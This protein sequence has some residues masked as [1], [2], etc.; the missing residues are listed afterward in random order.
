MLRILILIIGAGPLLF[1]IILI[2]VNPDN[3]IITD[4]EK[5]SGYFRGGKVTGGQNLAFYYIFFFTL[6]RISWSKIR[7]VD[8]KISF[9]MDKYLTVNKKYRKYEKIVWLQY[10]QKINNVFPTKNILDNLYFGG[11][12]YYKNNLDGISVLVKCNYSKGKYWYSL[13]NLDGL[14]EMIIF[15]NIKDVKKLAKPV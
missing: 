9:L 7:E 10:K 2:I 5:F 1:L 8:Y 11:L 13:H 15:Y 6:L 12:G 4:F 14:E 3:S